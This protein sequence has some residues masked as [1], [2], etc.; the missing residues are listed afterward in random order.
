MR[1]RD[2]PRR[3]TLVLVMTFTPIDAFALFVG[4]AIL[5]GAFAYVA[6]RMKLDW[7]AWAVL[8]AGS[9]PS[10]VYFTLRAGGDFGKVL[11]MVAVVATVWLFFLVTMWARGRSYAWVEHQTPPPP[12]TPP[13]PSAQSNETLRSWAYLL[14]GFGI[15]ISAASAIIMRMLFL[16]GRHGPAIVSFSPTHPAFQI[17][18]VALAIG[19]TML[20]GAWLLLHP[21]KS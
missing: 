15:P 7:M 9:L 5:V 10:V 1:L 12:V 11:T 8:T 16:P 2:N 13:A 21:A 20:G 19:L 18:A 4:V 6:V 14:M 17:C 3:A